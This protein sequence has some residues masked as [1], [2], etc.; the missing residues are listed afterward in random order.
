MRPT[1]L[2]PPTEDFPMASLL[3]REGQVCLTYVTQRWLWLIAGVVVL[4]LGL[5]YGSA[6]T[7]HGSRNEIHP[8]LFGTLALPI[9]IGGAFLVAIVKWQFANARARLLPGYARPHLLVM[10]VIWGA[11]LIL[12]PVLLA[13]SAGIAPWGPLAFTLLQGAGY[14]WAVGSKQGWLMLP[15]LAVFFSS[16]TS[17]GGRFWFTAQQPYV[18]LHLLLGVLSLVAL[19]A[20]IARMAHLHEEMEDYQ[21]QPIAGWGR[22]SRLESA[23]S[24]KLLGQQA[25]RRGI[26]NWLADQWHDHLPQPARTVKQRQRLLRYGFQRIPAELVG[27][28]CAGLLC[29]V[30][31]AGQLPLLGN[32]GQSMGLQTPLTIVLAIPALLVLMQLRHAQGRMPQE[33]L[34]PLERGEY[35]EGLWRALGREMGIIWLALHVS[36]V[37]LLGVGALKDSGLT[38]GAVIGFVLLSAAML[39][40]LF[41]AALRLARVESAIVMG[42]CCY[43]I[44][45]LEMGWVA[46]WWRA[47]VAGKVL[48]TGLTAAAGMVLLARAK[49]SWR[50]VELG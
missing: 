14:V 20:W 35:L 19:V 7:G 43:A 27:L 16:Y 21:V 33:L 32:G 1:D 9:L 37:G 46:L 12:N 30:V 42:L 2:S 45:A 49:Q 24:R 22:P 40:L 38:P 4:F 11:I 23:E 3:E 39:P 48:M 29:L 28:M 10:G 15:L 6:L 18:T 17:D 50:D 34:L 8:Q 47:P 41:A 25:N 5:G 44:V 36:L 26:F 31:V 13:W